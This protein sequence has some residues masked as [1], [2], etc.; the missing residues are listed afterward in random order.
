MASPIAPLPVQSFPIL[1]PEQ[2]S[3]H[4]NLLKNALERFRDITQTAY[5][6]DE[7]KQAL[8]LAIANAQKAQAEAKYAPQMQEAKLATEQSYPGYYN[9]MAGHN[10]AETNKINTMTPLEAEQMR[11]SNQY[12]PATAQANIDA[13]KAMANWRNMGGGGMG[14]GAK[15]DLQFQNNL[16]KDNPT[17][18]P[19][20][21]REAAEIVAS[22]GNQLSNGKP[23]NVSHTTQRSFD[24]AV[25]STSSAKLITAGVQANQADAELGVLTDH[26]RPVLKEIGTTYLN[27]SPQ[28]IADSFSSDDKSQERLGRIIGARSLQYAIAQ[29]RN[30][31]DMGEPGINA[32]KELMENSG[33]VINSVAPRLT[34]KAREEADKFIQEG[35]RKALKARNEAGIGASSA[36]GRKIVNPQKVFSQKTTNYSQAD[37]EHTA[38][39]YNMTVDQVK[40]QLGI[41]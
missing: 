20:E 6:P 1:T 25:K 5:L 31:I 27:K 39:K 24:R 16:S 19:E 30:R 29:L 17:F 18:T 13:Q 37:L 15:D 36:T 3:G 12:A 23:I 33:Q 7:K 26:V 14:T 41:G 11:I 8:A 10:I 2:M 9:S 34:A 4:G 28:Q 32:T 21:N 38:K 22:G 40:A 35:V